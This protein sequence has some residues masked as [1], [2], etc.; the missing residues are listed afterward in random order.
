MIGNV[1]E[2][3]GNSSLGLYRLKG[4]VISNNSWGGGG[5]GPTPL[6][7]MAK[8]FLANGRGPKWAYIFI[9]S[10]AWACDETNLKLLLRKKSSVK[11]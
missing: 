8:R 6:R 10:L 9:V 5:G 7:P 4:R 1:F 11:N 3:L 2:Y